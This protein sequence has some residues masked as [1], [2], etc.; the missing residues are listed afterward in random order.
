M[1]ADGVAACLQR[2]QAVAQGLA[3][4]LDN[5]VCG[6]PQQPATQVTQVTQVT[7]GQ[8]PTRLSTRALTQQVYRDFVQCTGCGCGGGVGRRAVQHEPR[9]ACCTRGMPLAPRSLP[10]TGEG[11]LRAHTTTV[12][13]RWDGGSTQRTVAAGIGVRRQLKQPACCVGTRGTQDATR[14]RETRHDKQRCAQLYATATALCQRT[15]LAMS[16]GVPRPLSGRVWARCGQQQCTRDRMRARARARADSEGTHRRRV[17]RRTGAQ[18]V[19]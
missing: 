14:G 1:E 19:R 6:A 18:W 3:A 17:R 8:Q 16:K 12:T 13:T 9:G 15:A 5:H 2:V 10:S 11:T 7:D 4:V